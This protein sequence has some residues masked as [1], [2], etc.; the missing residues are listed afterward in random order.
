MKQTGLITAAT[1]VIGLLLGGAACSP[2]QAS[3]PSPA[4]SSPAPSSPAP[5]G[6]SS[7]QASGFGARF[8]EA[9]PM[10]VQC[11]ITQHTIKKPPPGQPWLQGDRVVMT[12]TKASGFNEWYQSNNATVI[13]GKALSD[14]AE[15]AANNNKLPTEVC[16]PSASAS[17][18]HAE[19][20]PSQPNPWSS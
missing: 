12:G 17:K 19:V 4:P 10:L 18:I 2:S 8:L 15:W 13:G 20:F 16:G 5:S 3:P 7:G 14:W 1:A 9:P 6:S 11:G